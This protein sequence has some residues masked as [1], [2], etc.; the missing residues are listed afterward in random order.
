MSQGTGGGCNQ[1][2]VLQSHI[3]PTDM[4]LGTTTLLPWTCKAHSGTV[5]CCCC[6]CCC[7]YCCVKML[8]IVVTSILFKF[9]LAFL[10]FMISN[11]LKYNKLSNYRSIFA[12]LWN[13]FEY[14]QFWQ[15]D[16]WW[17]INVSSGQVGI[18]LPTPRCDAKTD[19]EVMPGGNV[20]ANLL[21]M[22]KACL[23]SMPK[24]CFGNAF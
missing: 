24:E 6:S 16:L 14:F 20:W 4:E 11:W 21:S 15:A 7:Y 2:R 10:S 12:T 23:R 22:P 13:I 18:V 1:Q 9:S 5:I 3:I 8:V 17:Q 19:N